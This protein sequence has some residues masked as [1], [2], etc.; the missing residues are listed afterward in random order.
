MALSTMSPG[1]GT[2]VN[3]FVGALQ[4]SISVLLT[5]VAG[6]IMAR[7]G[8]L[9]HKTVRNISKLCTSLFLPCLLIEEM[10]PQLTASNLRE[11]WIIP[12]WGLFSTVLAHGIGWVGKR[13]LKLPY[14]T[15]AASGRP[16]SNA[17]PLLLLQSLEHTGVLDTLSQPGESISKTL[18]RAKSLILLNAIVQQTFTFQFTPS[19]MRRDDGNH[20]ADDPESQ[21]TLRPGPGRLTSVVQDQE[22]VGLL[23][24]H[25]HDSDDSERTRAVEG[26]RHAL[27]DIADQPDIHWPERLRPLEK[28]LKTIWSH[29][30]P[31]LIGAMIALVVG[32]T[33]PLNKQ[34]LNEDG[35]LYTSVTQAI[36]NLGELFVVLQTFVVGAELAIVPSA[37]PGTLAM[38]W[39]LL[40]RFIIM[41]AIALLFVFVTAGRGL[42]VDDRLVW[43]LLV[44]IPAGPSAMLLV[45][46]AEL[47][48]ISQGAIAGYLTIA[49]MIS[50]F[51]AVVCSAGLE[52]VDAAAKRVSGV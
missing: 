29:M 1:I 4:G 45:N 27:D 17:L 52:V 7:R 38:S 16:N 49:Y 51:M 47:V 6:Y 37:N 26:Y 31:P 48:D 34:I 11:V 5:L 50:P 39:V 32:I 35:A 10:G 44:L 20:K 8:F 43:F 3:T 19:I 14:W 30:S 41:P 15:I 23:D 9:D 2:L 42:Y 18:D 33:P 24:D 28:P 46:V 21:D 40:V 36:V 25:E 22:R 12:L 13:L